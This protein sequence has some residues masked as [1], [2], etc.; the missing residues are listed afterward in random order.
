MKPE[1]LRIGNLMD[2]KVSNGKEFFHCSKGKV[3]S[4]NKDHIYINEIKIPSYKHLEPIEL[5]E[6]WLKKLGFDSLG[7][8]GYGIGIFHIIKDEHLPDKFNFPINNKVVYVTHVHQLQN[9]YFSLTGKELNY[10][11]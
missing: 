1:E 9:L 11:E 3:S 4:I 7:K 10:K 5:T 2:F 8:Y 6:E